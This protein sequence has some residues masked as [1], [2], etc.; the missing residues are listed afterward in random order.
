LVAGREITH[1]T[2]RERRLRRPVPATFET[3]LRGHRFGAIERRG[4]Y[5]LFELDCPDILLVHLGMSGS[6]SLRDNTAPPLRHDHVIFDLDRSESLC[7]N[8]PRRFGVVRLGVID[9]LEELRNVGPDPMTMNRSVDEWRSQVRHRRTPIKTLLMDQTFIAGIGNIYA[10]EILFQA[11]IRPR[12]MAARLTR[13]ELG[14]LDEAMHS[15][16]ARAVDLGGSSISD[17]RNIDGKLGYF[18]I[19]HAVYDRAGDACPRCDTAVR[20]IT[21]GGRST[22]YCRSCQR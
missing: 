22:F 5:L 3:R 8:D 2:V 4:K 7:F 13:Q 9:D 12:R 6:L 11:G 16:L 14:H 15:V 17:F 18:Q 20:K 10:N 19:H 1:V 21:L